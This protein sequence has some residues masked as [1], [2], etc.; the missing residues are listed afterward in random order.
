LTLLLLKKIFIQYVSFK[1]GRCDVEDKGNN[2]FLVKPDR[3]KGQLM[4]VKVCARVCVCARARPQTPSAG[5]VFSY[6]SI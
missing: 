6:L 3:R 2:K 4:L 5:R 1:A